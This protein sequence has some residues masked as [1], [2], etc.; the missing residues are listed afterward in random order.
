MLQNVTVYPTEKAVFYREHDDNAYS[1]T[2]FL[3]TYTALEIPFEIVTSLI[4]A[5][6]TVIAAGL[7]RTVAL[8]FVVAFNCF[9]I[10][11]S[12]ESVGIMFNTLFAHTGFAVNVTLVILGLAAI[13]GGV[14]SLDVPAFLQAW[15]HLSPIEWSLGNLA[16]YTLRGLNFTCPDGGEQCGRLRTGEEVLTL[17][18][19]DVDPGRNLAALGACV[20]IYR[21]VAWGILELKRKRSGWRIRS[22]NGSI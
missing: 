14:M 16:P 7:P 18:N 11:S 3:L 20:V 9:A 1:I 21:V 6:L 8:F 19:L 10:V 22:A 5:L 12:G 2:S 4:F 13:M 17:Y 15:N